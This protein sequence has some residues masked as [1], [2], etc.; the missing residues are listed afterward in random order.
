MSGVWRAEQEGDRHPEIEYSQSAIERMQDSIER[1]STAWEQMFREL[2]I[3][4]LRLCY[5][6]VLA[7]P[8]D[9]V[10]RVAG[11]LG[12]VI[13]PGAA[14]SVPEIRKQQSGDATA[15]NSRYRQSRGD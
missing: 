3:Q 10:E 4:P 13:D 15:W 9:T 7:S 1:Q 14:V 12:V 11:Y 2:E 6:D 5:E 8:E